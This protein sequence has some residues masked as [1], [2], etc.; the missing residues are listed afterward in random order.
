MNAPHAV[1]ET[2]TLLF[3]FQVSWLRSI[4]TNS[5]TSQGRNLQG[6]VNWHLHCSCEVCRLDLRYP[7]PWVQVGPGTMATRNNCYL[8]WT[9][10]YFAK[11]LNKIL[12]TKTKHKHRP[13]SY[14]RIPFVSEPLII[15][16]NIARGSDS[17]RLVPQRLATTALNICSCRRVTTNYD[18][19]LKLP[20]QSCS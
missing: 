20:P 10:R 12:K 18:D 19:P 3:W 6:S 11:I 15:F 13:G 17:E 9:W 16:L 14:L 5:L 8:F 1:T 7:Y 2:T 4:C